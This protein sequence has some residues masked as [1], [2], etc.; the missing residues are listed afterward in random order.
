MP[1]LKLMFPKF[2]FKIAFIP[3][4]FIFFSQ[5]FALLSCPKEFLYQIGVNATCESG[6]N[7][8]IQCDGSNYLHVMKAN[9]KCV[10][11]YY[12]ANQMIK[13][14]T[15]TG[16]WF[17]EPFQCNGYCDRTGT[18]N[19][20]KVLNE[21][22]KY[23]W[24]AEILKHRDTNITEIFPALIMTGRTVITRE[25]Y[26]KTNLSL[27]LT[28]YVV[29]VYDPPNLHEDFNIDRIEYVSSEPAIYKPDTKE[30]YCVLIL[31]SDKYIKINL[32]DTR[33]Y[34][35][36]EIRF[37]KKI[38]EYN[39][40][41]KFPNQCVVPNLDKRKNVELYCYQR[42]KSKPLK[43][44]PATVQALQT[45]CK[46]GYE[47]KNSTE[48]DFLSMC[49]AN[50]WSIN[51]RRDENCELMC[52]KMSYNKDEESSIPPW[53]A[54]IYFKNINDTLSPLNQLCSGVIIHRDI[55]LSAAQCFY[56]KTNNKLEG[57]SNFRVVAG[58]NFQDEKNSGNSE[59]FAEIS[60]IYIPSTYGNGN[61]NNDVAVLI[62]KTPLIF[63]SFV[64]PICLK[65]N[66]NSDLESGTTGSIFR[67]KS[68]HINESLENSNNS[69]GNY[70][71]LIENLTT[72]C[73]RDIGGGFF[74]KEIIDSKNRYVLKGIISTFINIKDYCVS[75]NV[76]AIVDLFYVQEFL[77][78]TISNYRQKLDY[79]EIPKLIWHRI[80]D[81]EIWT[82]PYWIRKELN[83]KL[84]TVD[85][86][87]F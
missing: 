52:G 61:W 36:D 24:Y 16:T 51:D 4:T 32:K 80:Y 27:N 34:C 50:R 70:C 29:R 54:A 40:P 26:F 37:W 44:C 35:L 22:F 77:K 82:A 78:T 1:K 86:N 15:R 67:W 69:S 84:Q 2:Y 85:P 10:E 18:K 79:K 73:N 58:K 31:T 68:N 19:L 41:P 23:P 83:L 59:Q 17:P 13:C 7:T 66:S 21:K 62:L 74:H 49:I 11:G 46:L 3:L 12:N 81:N 14:D 42:I 48:K 43:K 63:N 53:H 47:K 75:K 33:P 20:L 60:E 56:D 87:K 71:H 6:Y 39:L 55:I 8:L 5:T 9:I 28:D 72:I 38:P 76:A 45:K 64:S 30:P 65:L 25:K 57:S